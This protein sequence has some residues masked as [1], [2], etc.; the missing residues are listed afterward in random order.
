[1]AAPRV[2]IVL[3]PREVFSPGGTGAV[4]LVVH[5]LARAPSAFEAVVAGPPTAAPFA[6]T[7]FVAVRPPASV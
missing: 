4:G 5:R 7:R 1:M 3:P 2:V 6:D